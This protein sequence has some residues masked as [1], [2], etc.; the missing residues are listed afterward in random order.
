MPDPRIDNKQANQEVLLVYCNVP[1][2]VV[3]NHI[4]KQ[5]VAAR[6]AAC[7]NI[8]TGV[9]SIY[10][11]DGQVCSDEEVTL[12]IKTSSRN[13]I[14]LEKVVIE[15]HPYEVPELIAIPIKFGSQKYLEWVKGSTK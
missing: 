3:A 1:D 14:E 6:H 5:L 8:L 7:V 2:K 11:W 13:Y 10:V 9:Q 12:V 4:A 15:M